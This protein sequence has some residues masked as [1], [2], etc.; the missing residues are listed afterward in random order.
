MSNGGKV[1]SLLRRRF[2]T[3]AALCQVLMLAAQPLGQTAWTV[4]VWRMN[5]FH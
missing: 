1:H 5:C 2:W 3:A 4:H